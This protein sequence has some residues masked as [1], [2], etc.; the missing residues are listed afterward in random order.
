MSDLYSSHDDGSNLK[1][2]SKF[3]PM[4]KLAHSCHGHFLLL[5]GW[6]FSHSV[7]SLCNP[8]DCSPPGSSVHGIFP[9]KNTGVSCHFLLLRIFPT[10]GLKLHL[11]SLLYWKVESLPL[12]PPGKPIFLLLRLPKDLTNS[13]LAFACY[14]SR[15]YLYIIM[16]KLTR[17]VDPQCFSFFVAVVQV[18]F[19]YNKSHPL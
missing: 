19:I 17:Y 14:D 6:V 12:L 3:S 11:L 16:P 4:Y 9:G 2:F 5:H 15:H 10:Q 1:S 18:W 13:T 8:M 7:M